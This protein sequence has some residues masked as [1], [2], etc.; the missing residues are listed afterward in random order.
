MKRACI[1]FPSWLKGGPGRRHT[2]APVIA[3][4]SI[5]LLATGPSAWG[6][7]VAG[8]RLYP[9]RSR[10]A[11]LTA[12]ACPGFLTARQNRGND[13]CLFRPGIRHGGEPVRG[14]RQ[15]S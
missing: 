9:A 11:D 7:L 6:K 12:S 13:D 1:R 2:L 4:H 5:K 15:S 8:L 14:D 10:A 3:D